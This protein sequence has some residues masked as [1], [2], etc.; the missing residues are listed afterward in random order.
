MGG[1]V[2]MM[3]ASSGLARACAG[4]APSMPAEREDDPVPLQEGVFGPEEYGIEGRDP[5]GNQRCPISTSKSAWSRSVPW[6][7]VASCPR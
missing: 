6:G 3:V 1:L 5:A 2:A 4:L 7:R